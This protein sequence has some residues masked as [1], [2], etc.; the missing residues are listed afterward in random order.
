MAL[1]VT[2]NSDGFGAKLNRIITPTEWKRIVSGTRDG[3][4]AALKEHKF[5]EG[6]VFFPGTTYQ[7][8]EQL[9]RWASMFL[10]RDGGRSRIMV[11]PKGGRKEGTWLVP[12]DEY[13]E[14]Q[15][16]G[17]TALIDRGGFASE[18][19][20]VLEQKRK[21]LGVDQAENLPVGAGVLADRALSYE[22]VRDYQAAVLAA[23]G[24]RAKKV[25][26][27]D[28]KFFTRKIVITQSRLPHMREVSS[29]LDFSVGPSVNCADVLR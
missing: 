11:T 15:R 9:V 21:K 17:L 19:M 2:P 22:H 20:E 24:P 27:E 8:D 1:D 3:L 13:T 5:L 4:G 23:K 10:H 6:E 25:T 28:D 16:V 7:L 29:A 14:M 12:E 26:W 18:T